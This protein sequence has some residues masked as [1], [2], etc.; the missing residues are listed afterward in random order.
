[1]ASREL[2]LYLSV[3]ANGTRYFSCLR[4]SCSGLRFRLNL[5]FAKFSLAAAVLAIFFKY[6]LPSVL[7]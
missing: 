6:T 5:L 7:V 1:M 3:R 4:K 2:C